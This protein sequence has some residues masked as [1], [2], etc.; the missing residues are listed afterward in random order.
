MSQ[1]DFNIANQTFPATRSDLNDAL[2]AL[3]SLSGGA[4]APAT[5]Y[6]NQFWY[7]SANNILKLRNSDNDAWLNIAYIDQTVDAFRLLDDTQVTNTSG[8]QTGLIGGQSDATWAAGTGAIESLISPAQLKKVA[9][10]KGVA[11]ALLFG[12]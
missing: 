8:T 6:A 5:M 3:A 7:D 2:Q 1:H 9:V 11:M 10:G 4:T 12:S